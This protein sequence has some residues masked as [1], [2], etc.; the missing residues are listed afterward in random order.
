M[1]Y[2]ISDPVTV[3][4]SAGSTVSGTTACANVTIIDDNALEGNHSFTVNVTGL[5]LDPGGEYSELMIGTPPSATVN[6]MDNEGTCYIMRNFS[7]EVNLA[8]LQ[9]V[10]KISIK[11]SPIVKAQC[12]PPTCMAGLY[13][14]VK[15]TGYLV[16]SLYIYLKK[17]R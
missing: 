3:T 9:I 11:F 2:S 12:I 15:R 8:V 17:E 1:D 10:K 14:H 4:F 6:I 16:K 7:E 13:T 5:E